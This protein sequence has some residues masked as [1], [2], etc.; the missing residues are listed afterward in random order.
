MDCYSYVCDLMVKFVL[1]YLYKPCVFFSFPTYT[2]SVTSLLHLVKIPE[3]MSSSVV[4]DFTILVFNRHG[5][6]MCLY[7]LNSVRN[8]S[9]V[10]IGS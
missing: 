2:K 9:W 7:T 10:V 4:T 5:R 6:T 3:K 8:D 1:I